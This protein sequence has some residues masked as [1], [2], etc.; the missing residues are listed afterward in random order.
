[1]SS[2]TTSLSLLERLRQPEDHA[3]WE[4]FV[5]LYTPLIYYW[6]R[7]AGL[8]SND[9]AD[10]VQEVFTALLKIMPNFQLDP[11]KRF[12]NWLRTVTLN[13]WREK[14][15][16]KSTVSVAAEQLA[17]VEDP[18]VPEPFGEAEYRQQLV[19]RALKIMQAEF[20]PV[21]WQACWE[22]VV[23]ERPPAEI[24]AQFKIS[25]DSVYAAKSRVLR[26]LRQELDG[27][28]E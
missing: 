23:C 4:R 15:R 9:A 24:A 11:S 27:L 16:R 26:R 2:H 13:K 19:V 25:I 22:Y 5:R 18:D 20:H 12:R 28:L 8:Q 10:L 3:S 1:M 14:Q 6:A 17:A 21:T 7:N